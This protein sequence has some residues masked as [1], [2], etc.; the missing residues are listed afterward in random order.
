MHVVTKKNNHFY[1][2]RSNQRHQLEESQRNRFGIC[3]YLCSRFCSLGKSTSPQQEGLHVC[4]RN[5]LRE[6]NALIIYHVR[7][8]V[9]ALYTSILNSYILRTCSTVAPQ[10]S[11]VRRL[12]KCACVMAVFQQ[13]LQCD[14]P[15][16]ARTDHSNSLLTW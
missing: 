3:W 12:L 7:T 11:D 1:E 5:L 2:S 6:Y 9:V 13:R 14:Q 15:G 4:L 10:S 16:G 8:G